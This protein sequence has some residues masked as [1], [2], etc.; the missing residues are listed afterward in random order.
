[1]TGLKSALLNTM[2]VI[3][4]IALCFAGLELFLSVEANSA[5]PEAISPA[6]AA[7]APPKVEV[8]LVPNDVVA[9]AEARYR[10]LTM[11]DEWKQTPVNVRGAASAYRWHG[12][13]HVHNADSMRRI[14]PFPPKEQGVY[15]VMVVGDSLTYGYGIEQSATFVELLNK[16][17]GDSFKI[18]FLNLGVSGYQ[19]EDILKIINK[20]LPALA[21][22]LVVYTVCLNDFLP[23]GV[24]EYHNSYVVPIPKVIKDYFLQHTRSAAYVSDLYDGALRRLHI[25]QDFFDDIL[26]DFAGYQQRFGRDVRD[27]NATILAAGLPPLVAMVVDQYPWNPVGRKISAIAEENIMKAGATL[28]PTWGYYRS[29]SDK[30]FGVSRWEGHPNEVANYIWAH[31]I[32]ESLRPRQDLRPFARDMGKAVIGDIQQNAQEPKINLAK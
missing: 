10:F 20:F 23:S 19:S 31:M 8:A 28:I 15:R 30:S 16:Q 17:M 22:N 5:G 12:A 7:L 2:L 21:P 27:M 25:R 14:G 6:K 26:G 18:E 1:M 11:P 32:S 24:G 4:S 13:L 29:Y 3:V 9:A